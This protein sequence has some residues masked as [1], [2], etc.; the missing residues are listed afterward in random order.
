MRLTPR[1]VKEAVACVADTFAHSKACPFSSTLNIG[2]EPWEALAESF[3]YRAAM[4]R[5][6]LSIIAVA[7]DGRVDGCVINQDWR[8]PTLAAYK[9]LEKS[10]PVWRPVQEMFRQVHE[11]FEATVTP[12]PAP[13]EFLHAMYFASVRPEAR[14]QKVMTGLWAHTV[15]AAREQNYRQIVALAATNN[16]RNV[17]SEFLGFHE[18]ASLPYSSWTFEGRTPFS[19]APKLDP[20]EFNRLSICKRQVPSDLYV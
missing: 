7:P 1:Y 13:G 17:L 3:V 11:Q 9:A 19:E 14:G 5:Q 6:P 10:F 8:S 12:S 18:V 16:A 15:E 20:V 2:R 4:A